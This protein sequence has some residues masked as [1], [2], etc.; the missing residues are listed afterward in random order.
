VH[1]PTGSNGLDGLKHQLPTELF[2]T[3]SDRCRILPVAA[4]TQL[5]EARTTNLVICHASLAWLSA[6]LI[7]SRWLS[8]RTLNSNGAVIVTLICCRGAPP[9]LRAARCPCLAHRSTML[10]WLSFPAPMNTPMSSPYLPKT[11]FDV[12]LW[13]ARFKATGQEIIRQSGQRTER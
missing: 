5:D 3:D 7:W 9:C 6:T 8:H 11:V 10:R 12:Q 2:D 1:T 4:S 13:A